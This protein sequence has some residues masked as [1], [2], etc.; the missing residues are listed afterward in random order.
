MANKDFNAVQ[1]P[2]SEVK[3]VTGY[4]VGVNGAAVTETGGC[5]ESVTRAG[6]GDWDVVLTSRHKYPDGAKLWHGVTVVG[7]AGQ[8]AEP[9]AYDEEAGT[10]TVSGWTAAGAADD[11]D[12]LRLEV[13]IIVRNS[14]SRAAR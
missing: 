7:A 6:E 13:C 3:I 1:A 5:V 4:F 10:L 8:H 9:S 2:E 14:T 12:G 11:C